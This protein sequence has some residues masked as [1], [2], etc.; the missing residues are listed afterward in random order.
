[1]KRS[2]ELNALMMLIGKATHKKVIYMGCGQRLDWGEKTPE[3][4]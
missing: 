3:E 1:M 2:I 4:G